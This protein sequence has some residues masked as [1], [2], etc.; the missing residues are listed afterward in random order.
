ME[1][2]GLAVRPTTLVRKNDD[3]YHSRPDN[4]RH[5]ASRIIHHNGCCLQIFIKG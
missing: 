4:P 3:H 2:G 5:I 1:G